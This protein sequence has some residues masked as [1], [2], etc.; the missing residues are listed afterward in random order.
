MHPHFTFYWASFAWGALGLLSFGYGLSF[1]L[2]GP[3]R[4]YG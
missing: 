1:D 3:E 2:I 4:V